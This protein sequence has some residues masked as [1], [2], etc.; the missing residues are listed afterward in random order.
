MNQRGLCAQALSF[1]LLIALIAVSGCGDTGIKRI[2]VHGSVNVDG[3]PADGVRVIFC[4]VGGSEEM[5]KKYRPSGV[6]GPDGKFTLMTIT[7]DDG[8]P[9]G[10]YKVIAQWLGN[11]TD[12]FGR[13][14]VGDVDKFQNRY[15]DLQKSQIQAKVTG[16]TDLPPFDF[17]SK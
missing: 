6:T 4:P 1:A 5:Q 9:A 15:M 16:P 8:A 11:T 10:E 2:P 14:A 13:P 17:K 12:K 7:K 3:Q